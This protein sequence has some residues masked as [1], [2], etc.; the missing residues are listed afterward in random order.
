MKKDRFL[1]RP[2][3]LNIIIVTLYTMVICGTM[4]KRYLYFINGRGKFLYSLKLLVLKI[5][6]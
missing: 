5:R 3:F 1:V 6:T 4:I 2:H